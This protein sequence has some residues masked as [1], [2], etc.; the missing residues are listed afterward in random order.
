MI[1]KIAAACGRRQDTGPEHVK[2]A[3][4]LGQHLERAADD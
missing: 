1:T 2:A 4:L 3:L